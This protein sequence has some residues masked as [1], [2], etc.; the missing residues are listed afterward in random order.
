MWDTFSTILNI[1]LGILTVYFYLENT[2]LKGFEIDRDIELKK[3]EIDELVMWYTKRKE[4]LDN[5][6]A[7]RG[8]TSSSIRNEANDNLI[9]EYKNKCNKLRAELDYFKRLK[10]YK[11]IF[12]K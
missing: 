2:K 5:E 6:M 1:I 3:I 7:D 11:W 10:K 9:K 8:L 12:S 4:E